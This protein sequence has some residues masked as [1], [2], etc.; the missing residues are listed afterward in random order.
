MDPADLKQI[1]FRAW[2]T[3]RFLEAI[4]K[5]LSKDTYGSYILGVGFIRVQLILPPQWKDAGSTVSFKTPRGIALGDM[6][7]R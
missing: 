6:F 4:P 3:R 1:I 2:P 5:Q 7:S